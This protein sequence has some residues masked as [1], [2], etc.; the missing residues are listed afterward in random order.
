[1]KTRSTSFRA[2]LPVAL[3]GCAILSLPQAS[4]AADQQDT[5]G[6][7]QSKLK[8]SEYKN[9]QVRV[10]GGGVATL[11]GTVDLYEYKMN[12]DKA[13]HK[14]KGVTAVRNDI[15]VAGPTVP[16]QEL[17]K[18]LTDRLAYDRVGY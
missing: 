5:A 2:I 4:L 16:D 9:V 10:D 8:K 7:V 17:Q 12:A 6:A 3:L 13:A 1:M 18:R 14:A 15:Q 11:T